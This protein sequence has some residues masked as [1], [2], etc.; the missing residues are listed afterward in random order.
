[1]SAEESKQSKGGHERAKKLAPEERAE[2]ARKAANARWSADMP[3]ATHE[4]EIRIGD[5][6][7]P[8]AVLSTGKRLLTQGGFLRALG[9]SRSPKGGKGAISTVDGIPYFL[10]SEWLNPFVSEELRASTTPVFFKDSRG[11]RA[12]GYDAMLLPQVAEV[13]LTMRSALTDQG[14]SVPTSLLHI[15]ERCEVIV[16]GLARVG[17]AAL[18]DAATGYDEIRDRLALQAILDQYLLRQHATW[19]KRFPNEFYEQIFR[20]R[21]WTWKGMKVNRPSALAQYTKNIVYERI[22]P[23]LLKELEVRN[24][25]QD[26]GNRRAKHHQFL[27]DDVGLPALDEHL[28]GVRAL[29]RV[30]RNW[31][32]F[33]DMLDRA[34]PRQGD[35]PRLPFQPS[36][37]D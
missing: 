18:I 2:I 26:N 34:F 8:A 4:G 32:E 22:A 28:H 10:Q 7:I 27:T 11:R 20:L 12:V 30:S 19:A 23:G 37:E 5:I 36:K 31:G 3:A 13:Y 33:M 24:P 9:R 35:T 21:G 29:L 25:V 16:R 15:V 17:I 6:I 1:M 14:K